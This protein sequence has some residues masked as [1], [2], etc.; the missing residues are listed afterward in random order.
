MTLNKRCR[1]AAGVICAVLAGGGALL[2]DVDRRTAADSGLGSPAAGIESGPAAWST[3]IVRRNPFGLVDPPA[4][5]VT[6]LPPPPPPAPL[7]TVELT[8]LTSLLARK[9]ALFEII[10]GPGKQLI[11]AILA[12]G[13]RVETVEVITIDI[14]RSEVLI[15]NGTLVT[16]LTIRMAKGL[17]GPGPGPV[18]GQPPVK[19]LGTWPSPGHSSVMMAG[20]MGADGAGDHPRVGFPPGAGGP[21]GRLSPEAAVI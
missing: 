3:E 15:R 4:N 7:A 14:D 19:A 5:P 9:R 21:N 10:P 8:G 12:E 17:A 1:S 18:A 20:G 6:P 13:E 11:R 2:A 16:N